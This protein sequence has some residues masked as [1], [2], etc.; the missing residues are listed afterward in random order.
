MV[1]KRYGIVNSA[2]DLSA[3]KKVFQLIPIRRFNDILM[4]HALPIV[5]YGRRF[6]RES[7]KFPSISVRDLSPS[8]IVLIERGQFDSQH[9]RLHF[10]Q[11]TVP[12]VDFMIVFFGLAVHAQQSNRS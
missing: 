8:C 7:A 11:A 5:E 6:K 9:C 4:V 3:T 2:A 1:V 12:A 10:V